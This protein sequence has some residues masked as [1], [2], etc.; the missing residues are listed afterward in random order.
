MG[1]G[2]PSLPALPS[3]RL[4]WDMAFAL[5]GITQKGMFLVPLKSSMSK[6]C[7]GAE[8]GSHSQHEAPCSPLILRS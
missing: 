3:A 6:K 8:R 4:V 5:A 1:S 7:A 2:I